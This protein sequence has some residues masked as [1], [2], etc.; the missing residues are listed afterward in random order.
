MV[1]YLIELSAMVGLLQDKLQSILLLLTFPNLTTFSLV[2]A[3]L[4]IQ[5]YNRSGTFV[6]GGGKPGYAM[7]EV[8][9][10]NKMLA[11]CITYMN[12]PPHLFV[13]QNRTSTL[14]HFGERFSLPASET[15]FSDLT[16]ND[17]G[18]LHFRSLQG[19]LKQVRGELM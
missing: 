15:D 18:M 7:S 17:D 13:G 5:A 1:L 11:I 9:K 6:S 14:Y 3:F 16:I 10:T 8:I 19:G 2:A 4:L 12:F